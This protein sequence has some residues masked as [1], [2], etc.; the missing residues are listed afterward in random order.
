LLE[1]GKHICN[2]I[3]SLNNLDDKPNTGKSNANKGYFLSLD[4]G[5]TGLHSD[6]RPYS[7]ASTTITPRIPSK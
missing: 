6:E 5:L 3:A 7:N 1:F 2:A 4:Y